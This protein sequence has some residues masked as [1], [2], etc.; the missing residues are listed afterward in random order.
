LSILVILGG[1]LLLGSPLSVTAQEATPHGTPSAAKGDFAG[2]VDIG[3][4]SLWLTCMGE[5][6]PTVILES[7]SPGMTSADWAGVQS[8][9]APFTHVCAYD[10]ANVGRSDPAPMPRTVEQMADDLDALLESAG[11]PGPYVLVSF[12]FGPWV[13][14]VYASQHPD[15]VAGLVLIDG[16][17][18]DLEA[19]WKAV[20]P[21]DLAARWLQ[22]YWGGNPEGIALDESEDQVRDAAPLPVVPLIVIG[23]GDARMD[24][25]LIPTGWPGEVLDPIWKELVAKQTELV[26]G[27]RLVVAEQSSHGIPFEQPELVVAAV[28]EVVEAVRDPSSWAASATPEGG[29]P[30][31]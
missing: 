2:L 7:G 23:H 22:D 24:P 5:G 20:L 26:P 16:E 28:R 9:I 4:R 11:I 27:G 8:S 21:A 13:S 12:S 3:G 1:I 6:A 15:D 19:R 18:E 31:P 14:R 30:T 29:T 25:H 17:P 10:R